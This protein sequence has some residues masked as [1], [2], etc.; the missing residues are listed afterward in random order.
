MN[1]KNKA[2]KENKVKEQKHAK[3]K[4]VFKKPVQSTQQNL[5]IRE[6]YKG[7]VITKDKRY[8]K[9]MEVKPIT[10]DLKSYSDQNEIFNTFQ[11]VLKVAPNSVQ[12]TCMSFPA[13]LE[14]TIS[15][16]DKE[17][18]TER[19]KNCLEVDYA[20][21]Q[22]LLETQTQT[23]TRR[24]F[25]SFQYEGKREFLFN[26]TSVDKI[27][28]SLE[29]TAANIAS[30]LKACGNVV[31]PVDYNDPSG[32]TAEILYTILNRK[33]SVYK[34]FQTNVQEVAN[35]Y[36]EAYGEPQF[37]IPPVEYIAPKSVSFQNHK[38]VVVNSNTETGGTYY[39]FMYIPKFGY[40]SE[41]VP[42]WTRIFIN[43]FDGVD[44]NIYLER[45]PKEKVISD[46]RRN[47]TYAQVNAGETTDNTASFDSAKTSYISG[48]YLK[49][50][51]ASGQE[52]YYMSIML[53]ITGNSP[54]EVDDKING[55]KQIAI[56]SDIKLQHCN[57]FEENCFESALPLCFMDRKIWEKSK[58]NVLTEGAASTYPFTAFE[59]MDEN[60]I[61]FGDNVSNNSLALIDI[62]NTEKFQNPNV[63]ICGQSG[64]GKTYA[65]LLMAIR[66]RIKHIPVYILAPEKEH[67]FRRVC[68]ALGGQFIQMGAGSPNRINVMEIFKKDDSVDALI[69]GTH[70]RMSYLSEKVLSLKRFFQ[71]LIPDIDVE[72]K[73]LLDEAIIKTYNNFG[74]TSDNDS[75][76]DP[77]DF[78]HK[79][80]RKMP[81]ISDLQKVL[82]QNSRTTRLANIVNVLCTG[83]G[84]SFNGQTNVDLNNDFTVI[85][86]EHL[87]GDMMP[88][89][90]YM[91]MD[92][93][94]SKIK[95]DRT[96]QKA[97]FIDEWW[98][99]AYNPIAAEYSLEIAKVIR[100]YGGAMV[101][102]TQQ[103]SDILAVE[104]GKYGEAVLN[105]CKTKILMQMNKTDA[106]TV[107]RMIGITD[108][109]TSDIQ[110]S[111]KGQGL[112]VSNNNN[113][114][115]QFRAS[116]I[117]HDLITTDRTQL[118]EMIERQ[119]RTKNMVEFIDTDSYEFD[120]FLDV[121]E[122]EKDEQ[123]KEDGY[124]E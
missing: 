40:T 63:F 32:Q 99:L 105:N 46:I 72:E 104:N 55:L 70:Q 18:S 84:A 28:Y 44:T 57:F 4:R 5:P 76:I 37:Y 74:I 42:G 17:I 50:G 80:F 119:N 113:I 106:L 54:E 31:V 30:I 62:F 6:I 96:K 112:F 33:E 47:I 25:I 20:Y 61:Y 53:T 59:M 19:N 27:Y 11:Q 111:S 89:G 71:L 110:H 35:R 73:Q 60:G 23:V 13:N 94:W 102:A 21:R 10:F 86:L 67:E 98:K 101:I 115:I 120:D 88:L 39:A 34:S 64:A 78:M 97:L 43:S 15:I 69:D 91:A 48:N 41:V 38:Y 114:R 103:I 36:F 1:I 122:L 117:E 82:A 100:A 85:G 9:I 118:K 79:R 2:N 45:V 87:N 83:S 109:E 121:E 108:R 22:K 90:I 12:L 81:I 93:V 16:L 75:L 14:K 68:E 51:L 8:V 95:E 58:R 26:K 92:Y 116:K 24:F 29:Q 124:N 3:E 77:E 123:D 49:D 52:F 7:I 66:M 56:S 65:L 107:Q